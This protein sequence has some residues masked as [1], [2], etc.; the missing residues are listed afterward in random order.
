[1]APTQHLLNT[2][3]HEQAEASFEDVSPISSSEAY[4][5]YVRERAFGRVQQVM[6]GT[7]IER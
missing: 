7:K 5:E 2:M 1:M 4:G 3:E 6:L